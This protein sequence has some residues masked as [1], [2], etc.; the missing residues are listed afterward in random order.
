MLLRIAEAVAATPFAA[1]AAGSPQA[2]PIAN[3]LHLLGLVLLLGGIGL[4]DLRLLGAFPRLPLQPLAQALTPLGIAGVVILLASGSVLFAADAAALAGSETFRL[5]L[6]LIGIALGN[7]VAFRILY[8]RL[9]SAPV[10][11][12]AKLMAL[13]SLALWLGAATCGRLIA[14]S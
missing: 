10:G 14:Y 13:V 4:V 8:R 6:V 5:K 12:P 2:Y 11:P 9:D 7:A 3:V 1:W